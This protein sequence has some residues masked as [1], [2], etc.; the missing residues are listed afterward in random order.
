VGKTIPALDVPQFAQPVDDRANNGRHCLSW[1]HCQESHPSGLPLLLPNRSERRGEK[2][3][4]DAAHE[5]P[6]IHHWITSPTN[7][8]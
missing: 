3:T 1:V 8:S 2:A 7:G 6:S 5:C 4:S